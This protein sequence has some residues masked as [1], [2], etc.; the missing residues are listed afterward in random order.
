M[1]FELKPGN[2]SDRIYEFLQF[3]VKGSI[4]I[5]AILPEYLF[6]LLDLDFYSTLINNLGKL[7]KY[8]SSNWYYSLF[9]AT[10]LIYKDQL[11]IQPHVC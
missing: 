10:I 6:E 9:C 1:R 3:G 2:F 11:D 5:T 8:Y 4:I 7:Y